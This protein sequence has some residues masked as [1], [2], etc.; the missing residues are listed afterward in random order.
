MA[1]DPQP[2][3]GDADLISTFRLDRVGRYPRFEWQT[4]PVRVYRTGPH[5]VLAIDGDVIAFAYDGNA[6]L[7]GAKLIDYEF[8]EEY[9]QVTEVV[10]PPAE[11]AIP[12]ATYV[13]ISAGV[14][15]PFLCEPVNEFGQFIALPLDPMLCRQYAI[16]AASAEGVA[17]LQSLLVEIGAE[18]VGYVLAQMGVEAT[19]QQ[20]TAGVVAAAQAGDDVQAAIIRTLEALVTQEPAP[21]GLTQ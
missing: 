6:P 20:V 10:E 17:L 8:G 12:G 1:L 5:D 11:G 18:Y 15:M 7:I 16:S 13:R 21:A 2:I 9:A 19:A 3:V 4:L 14:A